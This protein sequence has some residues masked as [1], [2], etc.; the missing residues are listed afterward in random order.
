MDP[1]EVNT[2]S[3]VM[4]SVEKIRSVL[5]LL[6]LIVCFSHEKNIVSIINIKVKK[7]YFHFL[8]Y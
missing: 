2:V 6:L 5:V 3:K 7:I 1:I 4:V 8:Y